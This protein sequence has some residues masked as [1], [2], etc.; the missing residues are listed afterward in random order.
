MPTP[1]AVVQSRRGPF[2]A[3]LVFALIVAGLALA[4]EALRSH[5]HHAQVAHHF[6]A[7][8]AVSLLLKAGKSNDVSTA[9]EAMCAADV[10]QAAQIMTTLSSAGR[11]S[12]YTIDAATSR[13]GK[14]E[15]VA[16]VTASGHSPAAI[17][18]PVVQEGGGWH[19]C[20][21]QSTTPLT[22]AGAKPGSAPQCPSQA[23]LPGAT[24]N[25]YIF[26]AA[27]GQDALAQSCVHGT[28][29]A[30]SVAAGLKGATLTATAADLRGAGPFRYTGGGKTITVT[31]SQIG[32]RDF[33]TAVRGA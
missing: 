27:A 6:A 29:V 30:P 14:G 12:A 23:S 18:F 7:K 1:M 15:V 11:V 25:Q 26:A 4:Y 3:L 24:A 8:S 33:V 28:A 20:V 2:I 31:V 9:K 10:P 16:T 32:G 22:F 21:S 17:T 5:R 13:N 19:V